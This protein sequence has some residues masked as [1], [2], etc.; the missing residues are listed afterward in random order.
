MQLPTVSTHIIQQKGLAILNGGARIVA[1]VF[2]YRFSL[3]ITVVGV[4]AMDVFNGISRY[5]AE[6]KRHFSDLTKQLESL[7]RANEKLEGE[8]GRVRE[9]SGTLRVFK[10]TD[11]IENRIEKLRKLIPLLEAEVGPDAAEKLASLQ[12]SI[13]KL[14][15]PLAK[16]RA[17]KTDLTVVLTSL[18]V[19]IKP[20]AAFE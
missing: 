4:I 17:A 14:A 6:N 1:A 12:Q 5:L 19:L 10:A 2:S 15:I 16:L 13:D 7:Q 8:C 18:Q 9:E 20:L 11:L 3:L